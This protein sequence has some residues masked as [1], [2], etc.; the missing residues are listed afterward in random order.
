MNFFDKEFVFFFFFFF[1][2]GGGVLFYK[3][4]R[5]P[6]LAIVYLFIY[7]F[8][9]FFF[10]WGGGGKGRGRVSVRACMNKC[11]KWQ[12]YSSKRTHVQNRFEIHAY[13]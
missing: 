1:F 4:T 11:F 13:M 3:L 10:F 12:F 5:N 7:L 6:Y 2:G 8:I 9:Y